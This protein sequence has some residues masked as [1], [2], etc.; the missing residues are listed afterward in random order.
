MEIYGYPQNSGHGWEV[1]LKQNKTKQIE[2]NYLHKNEI[3][4]GEIF[5]HPYLHLSRIL[6][7][8]I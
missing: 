6:W 2:W 1:Y 3:E 4:E 5:D 7:V 8:S